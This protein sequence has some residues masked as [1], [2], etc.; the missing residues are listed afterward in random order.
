MIP[1]SS[2]KLACI[3]VWIAGAVLL[4]QAVSEVEITSEPHHHLVLENQYVRAFKVEIAPRQAT[5]MHR[6]RHDY[7]FVTIGVSKVEN[8]V[9]GKPAAKL[10]LSDG[11][12]WFLPGGFAHIARN[13]SD[14]PFRN[15]TIE[16]MQ[17]EKAR[18]SPPPKWDEER[19]LHVLDNGTQD[20]LFANDGVRVSEV[21]LQPGGIIPS[22]HH[23]GPHL[24]AAVS[25]LNLRSDVEGKG[26]SSRQLKSGDVAW[27]SGGFTHT[28]TNIA[29][30]EAKFITFEF[31]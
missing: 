24:V 12:T 28:V 3:L 21:D 11:E 9:E 18:Q 22:H 15:V 17:D 20:I 25:D 14:M 16:F 29:R 19:G 8:D 2:R 27:V 23:A 5:L 7:W 4:A 26:P 13:I 6:H 10:K 31:H 30:Q 1:G